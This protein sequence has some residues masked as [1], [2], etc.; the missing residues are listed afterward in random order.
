VKHTDGPYRQCISCR[1]IFRKEELLRFVRHEGDAA[2]FDE[3]QSRP[4]RGYYLC[5]EQRCFLN[6][7]KNRKSK[8]LF[9]DEDAM[10]YL[11]ASVCDT[12]LQSAQ[13]AKGMPMGMDESKTT[14]ETPKISP[15][16]RNLR[17]Y[18]RLSSKG[19]AL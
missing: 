8:A 9:R 1:G 13:I 10:R 11:L 7:W 12:L 18:E 6:A 3:R 5:P 14:K 17:F 15:I 19:R 16:L 4:G 2:V